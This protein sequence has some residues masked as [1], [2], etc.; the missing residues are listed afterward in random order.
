MRSDKQEQWDNGVKLY[1]RLLLK[2]RRGRTRI[3]LGT[4]NR[5]LRMKILKTTNITQEEKCAMASDTKYLDFLYKK[6][7]E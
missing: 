4:L 1:K 6:W 7:M 3:T 2:I 5:K